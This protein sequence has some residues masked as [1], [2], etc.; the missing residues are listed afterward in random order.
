MSMQNRR[1][2]VGICGGIAAYKAVDLVRRL[3][4]AGAEVQVV[5]TASSQ[6][7]IRPLSLQAAS[8]NEVHTDLLDPRA[9]AAMGHIELAQMGRCGA[10]GPGH[11]RLHGAPGGRARR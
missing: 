4:L 10:G 3:C 8:G 1:V 9:E 5:M 11:R 2:L 7:F 6:D